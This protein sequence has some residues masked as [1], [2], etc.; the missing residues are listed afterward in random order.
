MFQFDNKSIV[1]ME[2]P[3]VTPS[4][5]TV[6]ND[7]TFVSENEEGAVTK[8]ILTAGSVVYVGLNSSPKQVL[9]G[10]QINTLTSRGDGEEKAE[11]LS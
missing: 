10:E 7:M 1:L 4:G 11:V 6:I 5:N 3:A 2:H 8:S 9:W